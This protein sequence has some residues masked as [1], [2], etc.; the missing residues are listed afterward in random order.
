[1][2]NAGEGMH[3]ETRGEHDPDQ[4]NQSFAAVAGRETSKSGPPLY[5]KLKNLAPLTAKEQGHQVSEGAK[6]KTTK[7]VAAAHKGGATATQ[8]S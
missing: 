6:G 1:M 8:E 4:L 7:G 3:R 5:W 2:K